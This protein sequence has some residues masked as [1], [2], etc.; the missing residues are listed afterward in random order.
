[1]L[2]IGKTNL[3]WIWGSLLVLM[4]ANTAACPLELPAMTVKAG[5]T[6]L[7]LEIAATPEARECGLSKRNSLPSNAGMLF[8]LPE[9]EPFAVWMKNTRLPLAVAFLGTTGRI[10]SIQLMEPLRTDVVYESPEPV[11]YAIE[12]HRGWFCKHAVRVGDFIR[13]KL[14][15]GLDIR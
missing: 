10:L 5:G 14:P 12:V 1:M 4:A 15:K 8:V 9:P 11:R 13:F 3:Q 7:N 6:T 2:S